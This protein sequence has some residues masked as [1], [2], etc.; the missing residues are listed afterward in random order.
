MR[1]LITGG[2]TAGHVY[3]AL[4]VLEWLRQTVGP[5]LQVLYMGSPAGMEREIA[6]TEGLHYAAVQTGALRGRNPVGVAIGGRNTVLGL[7]NALSIVRRFRPDVILAT[8]GYVSA[9]GVLAGR[10]VGVGSVV[11]LPDVAPGWAVRGLS[12]VAA[13]VATTTDEARRYLP[14]ARIVTT[15]YPVRQGFGA[16]EAG[17][18]RQY[19]GLDPDRF[20]VSVAGGSLGARRIND[21]IWEGI[22]RLLNQ[23]QLIHISGQADYARLAEQRESLSAA[24]QQRYHLVP[25]VTDDM[26]RVLGAADLIVSRAGASTLGEYPA[27]GRASLL[28]PGPFSSQEINARYLTANGAAEML[29]NEHAG[30][31]VDRILGLARQPEHINRMAAA[32]RALCR[33]DAA[34]S[35]GRLVV[36]VANRGKV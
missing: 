32:A 14:A 1:L 27:V 22:E 23:A 34:A 12:R 19:F 6:R 7:V 2:G 4:V 13:V 29:P 18:A 10:L 11:Y 28:V 15:G 16:V 33:P 26:P 3:P 35:I 36:H 8:G 24:Q 25:Y 17:Q 9:P 5:S 21:A 30:E 20:T 31:L